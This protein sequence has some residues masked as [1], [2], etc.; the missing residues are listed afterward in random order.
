MHVRL[1]AEPE[2]SMNEAINDRHSQ[3]TLNAGTL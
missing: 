2:A 3:S 1:N